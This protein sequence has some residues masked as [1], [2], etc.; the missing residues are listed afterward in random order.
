MVRIFKREGK[1]V[2]DFET[3]LNLKQLLDMM[4]CLQESDA[5]LRQ[6]IREIIHD[7]ILSILD[8]RARRLSF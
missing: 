7:E 2:T 8:R 1:K 5:R 4:I 6:D 3:G